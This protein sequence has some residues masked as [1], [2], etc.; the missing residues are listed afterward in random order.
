MY[1]Y[2]AKLHNIPSNPSRDLKIPTGTKKCKTKK[3]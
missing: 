1:R 2:V 3:N